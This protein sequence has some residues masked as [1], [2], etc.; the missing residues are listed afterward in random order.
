M[1]LSNK[2]S[3]CHA[4]YGHAGLRSLFLQLSGRKP[5]MN[6]EEEA[7]DWERVQP[8]IWWPAAGR[9]VVADRHLPDGTR[10]HMVEGSVPAGTIIANAQVIGAD[11]AQEARFSVAMSDLSKWIGESGKPCA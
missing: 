1:G 7:M 11:D 5:T 6:V 9:H 4:R 3:L 10:Q 2:R 8:P